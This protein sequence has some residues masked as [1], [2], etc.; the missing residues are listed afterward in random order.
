[1]I[2]EDIVIFKL[3]IC[4]FGVIL[5]DFECSKNKFLLPENKKRDSFAVFILKQYRKTYLKKYFF[6]F[7]EVVFGFKVL[8][9]GLSYC[10]KYTLCN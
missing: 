9:T 5:T 2:F 3:L 1:M 7:G 8:T 4:N 6:N 10:T